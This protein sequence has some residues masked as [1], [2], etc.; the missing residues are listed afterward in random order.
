MSSRSKHADKR[1]GK[2]IS[3]GEKIVGLVILVIVIWAVYSLAQP[4]PSSPTTT[5]GTPDFTLPVVGPN[6]LTGQKIS[7]SSFHGKVVFLEFMV[8]WC[9]HCQDMAP[10]LEKLYQQYGPQNVVFLSVSG[11]WSGATADDAA[12]FIRNYHSTWTYVYDSSGTTFNAWG[13]TATPSFFIIA[14]NGQVAKSYQGETTV[15]TIAADLT[16]LNS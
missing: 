6:G 10:A 5:S 3:L 7:L 11:S 16:R 12:K 15:E 4:A 9:S 14:K 2:G 8:P 1:R 13:V